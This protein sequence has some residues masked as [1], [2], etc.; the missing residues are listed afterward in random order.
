MKK[1]VLVLSFL[2]VGICSV[3]AHPIK[4]TTSKMSLEKKSGQLT[5]VINFFIDDFGA[6]LQ[7][8]YHQRNLKLE[9]A[10]DQEKAMIN[11]YVAKKLL[12]KVNRQA[13][14]LKLNSVKKSEDNVL[15]VAFTIPLAS[16]NIKQLEITNLLLFD[17]FPDEQVNIVHL[18][19][20][21]KVE[22]SVLQFSPSDSYK[23]VGLN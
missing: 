11:A 12:I 21:S 9:N 3:Q 15:Q 23:A 6:H 18:D 13:L 4:M 2:L 17:A 20:Q 10:G 14:I 7:K 1:I 22:A 19:L 5:I 8:I 16:V